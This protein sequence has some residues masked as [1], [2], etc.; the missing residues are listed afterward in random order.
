MSSAFTQELLKKTFTY[1]DG[2]LFYINPR[3]K[4]RSH[5]PAGTM[6]SQY[7]MLRFRINGTSINISVHRVVFMFHHGYLPPHIDHIDNDKLNNRI[8]NLRPSTNQQNM[9]NSKSRAGTSKY[10]GVSKVGNKWRALLVKG[11]L[12]CHLGYFVHEDDAAMAYNE[13]ASVHFGEFARGNDS[14]Y[15]FKEIA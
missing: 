13:S 9:W 4:A 11:D 1:K 15:N 12:K 2:E 6:G 10:K 8:E 7:R 14:D 3:F 5:L